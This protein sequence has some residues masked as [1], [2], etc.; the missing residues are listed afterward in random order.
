[1]ARYQSITRLGIAL[2]VMLGAG[3]AG[4]RSSTGE[5]DVDPNSGI[6]RV[7]AVPPVGSMTIYVLNSV[8]GRRLVGY[9]RPGQDAELPFRFPG[10]GTYRF[11]AETLSQAQ[12]VS[13]TVYLRPGMEV[14]W[15]LTSNIALISE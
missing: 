8:G 4:A 15:D 6:L 2:L 12:M 3:C 13:N 14:V 11:L 1:M 10:N 5:P 7:T 9:V